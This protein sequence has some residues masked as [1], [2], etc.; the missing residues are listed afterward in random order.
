MMETP[1]GEFLV[2][3][4]PV[5]ATGGEWEGV[6][7][8]PV[9]SLLS[10]LAGEAPRPFSGHMGRDAQQAAPTV[11]AYISFGSLQRDGAF[12]NLD[13][14]RDATGPHLPANH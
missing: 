1:K 6:G 13:T 10:D 4:Y 11:C 3:P 5:P 14:S 9:P 12:S 8:W 7:V 2:R